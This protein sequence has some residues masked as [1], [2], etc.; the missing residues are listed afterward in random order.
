MIGHEVAHRAQSHE[1]LGIAPSVGADNE[2]GRLH[3]FISE[4]LHKLQCARTRPEA[5]RRAGPVIVGKGEGLVGQPVADNRHI[6]EHVVALRAARSM[7]A[8]ARACPSAARVPN[9]RCLRHGGCWFPERFF[10][11]PGADRPRTARARRHAQSA[12][13]TGASQVHMPRPNLPRPIMP[14]RS[15]RKVTTTTGSPDVRRSPTSSWESTGATSGE[16]R[17]GPATSFLPGSD[18]PPTADRG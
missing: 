3:A 14:P 16:R 8:P 2:E 17:V 7:T 12:R 11:C 18:R 5:R 15:P 4:V 6:E 1:V 10:G 13:S 9:I